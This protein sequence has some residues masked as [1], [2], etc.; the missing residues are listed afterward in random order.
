MLQPSNSTM[1][2]R[3]TLTALLLCLASLAL[4]SVTHACDHHHHHGRVQQQQQHQHNNDA[5]HNHKRERRRL[6]KGGVTVA[7]EEQQERA[8]DQHHHHHD[9]EHDADCNED[10]AAD[11]DTKAEEDASRELFKVT[12]TTDLA[13]FLRIGEVDWTE[14]AFEEQGGRCNTP[15]PDEA[16]VLEN[17]AITAAFIQRFGERGG[18]RRRLASPTIVVPLYFHVLIGNSGRGDVTDAQIRS[19]IAVL[20]AA[21]SPDFTFELQKITRTVNDAWFKA[22]V[23]TSAERSFKDQLREGGASALN[24][25]TLEPSDGV[26]GWATLP[27]SYSRSPKAD[28]VAVNWG[29]LPNGSITRYN[30]GMFYGC[31]LVV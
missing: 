21:F 11:A 7:K 19:Q 18:Y 24:F 1:T 5:H 16:E 28:G 25:Y 6:R 2:T 27:S 8:N 31:V 12:D 30:E 4:V 13:S 3:K 14:E 17:D 10:H 15:A 22:G 23:G 20:D 9:D 29:S 26:L